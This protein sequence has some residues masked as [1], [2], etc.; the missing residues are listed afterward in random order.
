MTFE[1]TPLASSAPPR[2]VYAAPGPNDARGPC[3]L[4]NTMANHGYIPRDGKNVRA[5]E[6]YSAMAVVGVSRTLAAAFSY[7]IFNEHIDP[8]HPAKKTNLLQK[9]WK[10]LYNPWSVLA[11]LG[12]RNPNQVDERGRKVL[13][14][15][16]LATHGAV[17]HDI[18]LS[19]RDYL[20]EEG[21]CAK[22]PDL[23]K[24]LLECSKDGKTLTVDD[25][26]DLRRLR[27][28]QQT[29]DNPG[30]VY[31]DKQHRLACGEIALVL[32]VF[33]NGHSVPC[34]YARALFKEERLPVEEGW[35]RRWWTVGVIELQL[36]VNKV[37]G[38]VGWTY[39]AK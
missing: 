12:M 6:L 3:P 31:E 16:Q 8:Q 27:I 39:S 19:R 17:E 23:I 38:L 11:G 26:A 9:L 14:L 37:K 1:K 25:L 33:G 5:D 21:N 20:Q 18:S 2:G 24:Q 34:S 36:L 13:N 28:K 10:F 7:P 4:V 15:D 30:L 32:S 35:K 22:Q 29:A